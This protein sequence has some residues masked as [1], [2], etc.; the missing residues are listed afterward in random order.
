M[1]DPLGIRFGG[2]EETME[3]ILREVFFQIPQ[4]HEQF[5]RLHFDLEMAAIGTPDR[6]VDLQ[7]DGVGQ[8]GHEKIVS[9]V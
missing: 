5:I 7:G 2:C 3:L 1:P 9:P 8:P 4:D 6:A